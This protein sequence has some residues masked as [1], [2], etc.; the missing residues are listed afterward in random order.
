MPDIDW[1]IR[2]TKNIRKNIVKES[3]RKR[4]TMNDSGFPFFVLIEEISVMYLYNTRLLHGP[5]HLGRFDVI[6][7]ILEG[8][9]FKKDKN[10]VGVFRTLEN[11]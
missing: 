5:F 3:L 6:P 2:V 7:R 11:L 8:I 1:K 9:P 4:R 10:V